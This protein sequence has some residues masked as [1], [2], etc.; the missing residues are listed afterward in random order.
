MQWKSD[1]PIF[2]SHRHPCRGIPFRQFQ[3]W[4]RRLAASRWSLPSCTH[5]FAPA[6][7]SVQNFCTSKIRDLLWKVSDLGIFPISYLIIFKV[8]LARLTFFE[9]SLISASIRSLVAF[10]SFATLSKFAHR[11]YKSSVSAC[12][13]ICISSKCKSSFSACSGICIS[14]KYKSSLPACSGICIS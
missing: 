9:R 2:C 13:G 8:N 3:I 4:S 11:W 7:E 6:F 5:T 10:A 14:F 1:H 12:S